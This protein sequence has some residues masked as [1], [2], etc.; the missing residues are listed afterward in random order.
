MPAAEFIIGTAKAIA[1]PL[2]I[3]SVIIPQRNAWN[4]ETLK[5]FERTDKNDAIMIQAPSEK[6]LEFTRF[7]SYERMMFLADAF[8]C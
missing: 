1:W 4:I 8:S 3:S 6:A 5:E 2:T 7:V